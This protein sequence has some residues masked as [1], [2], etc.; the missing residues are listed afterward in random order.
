MKRFL[1]SVQNE[2]TARPLLIQE[3]SACGM[4]FSHFREFVPFT[5]IS[6][7]SGGKTQSIMK[8]LRDYERVTS[9]G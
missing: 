1:L 8:L 6:T 3:T 7:K 5:N 9:V 2:A 4:G